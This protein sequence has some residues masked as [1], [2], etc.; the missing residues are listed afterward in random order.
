[1]L[2][3]RPALSQFKAGIR[4]LRVHQ[5]VKNLLVFV[6]LWAA[7]IPWA[8]S[9]YWS[10]GKAFLSFCL[11]ASATYIANDFFDRDND[12]AHPEKKGRPLASAEISE[13]MASFAFIFCLAVG[14]SVGYLLGPEFFI[15]VVGYSL[16][17][18]AY[19]FRLKKWIGV[20]IFLLVL[21]Y[22]LRIYAGHI[23]VDIDLSGWLLGFSFFMFLSLATLKRFAEL[24]TLTQLA[25]KLT[26][27]G[28][29]LR[30]STGM[31]YVGCAASALGCSV[32]LFYINS[33]EA[34]RIYIHPTYLT[35]AVVVLIIWQTRLWVSAYNSKIKSDPVTFALL[36][37]FSYFSLGIIFLSSKFAI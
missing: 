18:L 14:W 6:P 12:R 22:L 23:V 7:Q 2:A 16:L 1:M 20:D 33:D 30:H 13:L 29:T 35:C 8:P 11:T 34:R 9:M 19:S 32:L 31:F 25:M 21:F 26:G 15:I 37:W 28:Y 27:R 17:T 3:K 4:L 10:L 5:W 36:D 24:R